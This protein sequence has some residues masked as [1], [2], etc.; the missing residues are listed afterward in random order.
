[1]RWHGIGGRLSASGAS[2]W[3]AEATRRGCPGSECA[4]C[5]SSSTYP[6]PGL[7]TPS[8]QRIRNRQL[9]LSSLQHSDR[10]PK[11]RMREICSYGSVG[12]PVG[13]HRRYPEVCDG[14]YVGCYEFL[15]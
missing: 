10:M 12:V 2:G 1:M 14:G 8:M 15:V 3:R 9:I 4:A 13:N 5:W 11:N 6:K 7:L